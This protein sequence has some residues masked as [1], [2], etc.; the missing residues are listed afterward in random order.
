MRVASSDL[1]LLVPV[2]GV[3]QRDLKTFFDQISNLSDVPHIYFVYEEGSCEFEFTN[4]VTELAEPYGVK[5]SVMTVSGRR[6]I[7]YALN[8]AVSKIAESFVV[9]HDLG[10]DFISDRFTIIL[11]VLNQETDID[12]I[13]SQAILDVG[14][15]ERL[16]S[17]PENT[18]D[19]KRSFIFSNA[20]CH[21]TV[22][23]R[24]KSIIDLG[25]YDPNL[26]F[27]E[28]LDLWLRAFKQNLKFFCI[29]TPTIR[30]FA[31][32]KVR[33]NRN[34]WSNLQVRLKNFGSPSLPYS[35]MGVILVTGFLIL[36]AVLK[37]AVYRSVK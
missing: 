21:P 28:D 3:T 23:F 36:P 4:Y 31:P 10:D 22:V 15:G 26:R 1:A 35:I 17:Y 27:C 13:Y 8:Y 6:G 12:I 2:F 5:L 30:Y 11:K 24:R 34:W 16:S 7:G 20:I 25:N 14:R 18:K 29:Q 19:L 9:R 33:V 32:T 37:R